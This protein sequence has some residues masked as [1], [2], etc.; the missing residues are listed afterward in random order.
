[1]G[2][3]VSSTALSRVEFMTS[4]GPVVNRVRLGSWYKELKR[5]SLALKAPRPPEAQVVNPNPEYIF[6]P[7]PLYEFGTG[8]VGDHP[9]GSNEIALERIVEHPAAGLSAVGC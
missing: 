5:D 8:R 1:M 6:L 9:V 4:V 2:P 3:V 7:A